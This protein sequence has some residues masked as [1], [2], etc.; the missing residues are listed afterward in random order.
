MTSRE[1]GSVFAMM[2]KHAVTAT[3]DLFAELGMPIRHVQGASRRHRRM[4]A[5][6]TAVIGFAAAHARGSLVMCTSDQTIRCWLR[7]MA[8]AGRSA[9]ACDAL[10]EFSNML[11]ARLQRYLYAEGMKILLS[12]PTSACG[13]HLIVAPTDGASRWFYF[14]RPGWHLDV[15]LDAVFDEAFELAS[16]A[17]AE[18]IAS[19]GDVILF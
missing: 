2:Q 17:D 9:D 13:R 5:T 7:S 19:G 16:S 15:R 6:I 11:L 18:P 10:G 1:F 3:K 8:G 4:S 14:Q 12:T